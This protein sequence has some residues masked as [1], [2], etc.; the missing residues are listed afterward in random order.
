[1][2]KSLL[3]T[4]GNLKLD[5]SIFGW[6]IT[7]Q[8]SCLNS[9]LCSK[10]CYAKKA[11]RLYPTVKIAWDRN[12]NLA[13]TGEF[14]RI[15]IKQI[16][17]S[18]TCK[19]VRIHVAGDFFN[20]KYIDQWCEII[21]IFPEF[22]FYSYTKVKHLFDFSVIDSFKNCNIINSITDEGLL[23][24]GNKAY[25]TKLEKD[26]YICCPVSYNKDIICGKDCNICL[27]HKKVCFLKH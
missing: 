8:K 6:S 1:M 25:I 21:D 4:R 20:Q 22:N 10:T 15:L 16:A 3:L 14:K 5:R 26:G 24:F 12:F 19:I 27:D 9:V 17:R 18:Y 2:E 11:Y 13:K 7:P 23:N